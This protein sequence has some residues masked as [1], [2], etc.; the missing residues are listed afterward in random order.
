MLGLGIGV[1]V[2]FITIGIVATI[3]ASQNKSPLDGTTI[4]ILGL[5]TTFMALVMLYYLVSPLIR[6][7]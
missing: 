6:G 4:T 1:I 3:W 2:A 5:A 7:Q